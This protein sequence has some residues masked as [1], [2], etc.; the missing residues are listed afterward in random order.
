MK[1]REK[2]TQL[3]E[4][5]SDAYIAEIA[6]TMTLY[7]AGIGQDELRQ[8]WSQVGDTANYNIK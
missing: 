4:Q 6:N 7:Y 3:K 1:P 8:F 5:Y 2:Y